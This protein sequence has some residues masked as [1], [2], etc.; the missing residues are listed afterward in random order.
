[1]PSRSHSWMHHP[2]DLD[3]ATHEL[4]SLPKKCRTASSLLYIATRLAYTLHAD[5]NRSAPLWCCSTLEKLTSLARNSPRKKFP[6]VSPS[7]F[8]HFSAPRTAAEN[9]VSPETTLCWSFSCAAPSAT[10]KSR[11]G[12]L[13]SPSLTH[14][15]IFHENLALLALIAQSLRGFD[16]LPMPHFDFPP[17]PQHWLFYFSTFLHLSSDN[18]WKFRCKHTYCNNWLCFFYLLITE[19]KYLLFPTVNT[20]TNTVQPSQFK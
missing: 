9:C 10:K 12:N 16:L 7:F 15:E 5:V 18:T 14:R 3:L 1:L 19:Q 13:T 2:T 20:E 11:S 8:W 17:P 6:Q 4:P